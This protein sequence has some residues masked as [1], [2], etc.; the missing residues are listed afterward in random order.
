MVEA[1]VSRKQPSQGGCLV[2][3]ENMLL[4]FTLHCQYRIRE[5]SLDVEHIKQ[6]I[7]HPD[8]ARDAGEG[9]TK[10]YKK[11]GEEE[12]VVVYSR[13][14]FRDRKNTYFVITAYYL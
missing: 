6:A 10:V 3:C 4:K 5:R 7:Q 1:L 12:I 13:D 11:I 14:G 8:K 9:A 2:Y